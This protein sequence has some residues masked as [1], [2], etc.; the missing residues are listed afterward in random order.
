MS[1]FTL[2]SSRI[3]FSPKMVRPQF[4]W[5]VHSTSR[6]NKCL[7]FWMKW[8]RCCKLS[9]IWSE[10]ASLL[11]K[12]SAISME[13]TPIWWGSLT[14]GRLH[15]RLVIFAVMTTSSWV[16]M[17]T[18]E[19]KAWRLSAYFWLLSWNIHVRFSSS[20]EITKTE[21]LID[22]LDLGR[23]VPRD[24]LRTSMIPTACSIS[25]MICLSGSPLPLWSMTN[26][27]ET[28]SCVSMEVL[29]IALERQRTS[30][31]SRDLSKS[32]LVMWTMQSNR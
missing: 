14:F 32:L 24:S 23:N 27:L 29:E 6:R 13:I 5:C 30:T 17:W 15:R 21:M 16:T 1:P 25:S 28:K 8:P 20:E 4:Q 7:S 9:Q 31:K 2:Y 18:E 19:V 11:S 22:I 12:C 3:S 26:R 10:L